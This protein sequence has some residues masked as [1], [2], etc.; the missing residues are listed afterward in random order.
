MMDGRTIQKINDIRKGVE[1]IA[2]GV[3][4]YNN[5]TRKELKA[6]FGEVHSTLLNWI[7]YAALEAV[8]DRCEFDD[9]F[10]PVIKDAARLVKK[11]VG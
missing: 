4:S 3:N 6:A 9:R 11:A 1:L 5:I 10:Y 7:A 2:E 8:A